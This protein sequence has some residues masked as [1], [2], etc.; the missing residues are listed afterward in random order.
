MPGKLWAYRWIEHYKDQIG[1]GYLKPLDASRKQA[2]SAQ[3]YKAYFY[4]IGQKIEQYNIKPSNQYN[5][6]E[7]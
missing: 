4:L 6:D 1:V 3:Y 7:K 2:D 5:M